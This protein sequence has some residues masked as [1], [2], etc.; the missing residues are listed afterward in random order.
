MKRLLMVTTAFPPMASGGIARQL[1]FLKYLP[2]YGWETTVLSARTSGPVPDP[3]GVR[4]VRAAAPGPRPVLR[5]GR[6][7]EQR[8]RRVFHPFSSSDSSSP[9]ARSAPLQ[10][11]RVSNKR[12]SSRSITFNRWVFVPDPDVGWIGPAIVAGRRLLRQEPFDAILS[13]F[14]SGSA[15]LVAASLARRSGLPWIADYRDPWPTNRHYSYPTSAHRRAAEHLEAWALRHAAAAT[16]VNGPIADDLRRRHPHLADRVHVLPNGFDRGE[17]VADVSLGEGFWFVYTGR[18]Y[19]RLEQTAHFL[20]AMAQQA[21]DVNVLFLGIDDPVIRAYAERLGCHTRVHLRP[22]VQRPQA[23]GFQRAADALLLVTGLAPE[24]LSSKVF[25][26]LASGRPVFAITPSGSAAA[27]LLADAGGGRV[28]PPEADLTVAL[29]RFIADVRAGA[30][31]PADEAALAKYD[32]RALTRQLSDWLDN[33]SQ[34]TR[35]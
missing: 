10:A 24:S 17:D 28:V 4:I 8:L 33:V 2:E 18:L 15:H 21:D 35:R 27:R 16:A 23:L 13:S 7:V 34:E 29:S 19:R 11:A 30:I 25:E 20:D 22:F 32:G 26:Y 3:Q 31:P 9:G 5:M 1:R 6:R 12:H 14:P